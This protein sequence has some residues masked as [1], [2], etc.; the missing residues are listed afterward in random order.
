MK[1]ASPR[2]YSQR[3]IETEAACARGRAHVERQWQIILE[4]DM[5]GADTA[6]SRQLLRTYYETLALH[7]AA[8]ARLLDEIAL[9][10]EAS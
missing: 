8:L 4:K 7:E 6:L 9:R 10:R 1:P 5:R 3:L 2:T